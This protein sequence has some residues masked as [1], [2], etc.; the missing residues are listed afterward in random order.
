MA[1]NKFEIIDTREADIELHELES[2]VFFLHNGGVFMTV[3]ENHCKKTADTRIVV[4]LVFG[5]LEY[6]P[7]DTKIIRVKQKEFKLHI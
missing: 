7:K 3:A 1:V 4:N 5:K 2:G 6:M